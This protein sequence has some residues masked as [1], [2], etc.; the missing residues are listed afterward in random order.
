LNPLIYY[1]LY[2]WCLGFLP[3]SPQHYCGRGKRPKKT[4]QAEKSPLPYR[5]Y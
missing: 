2:K 3:R 1:L 4:E 5:R